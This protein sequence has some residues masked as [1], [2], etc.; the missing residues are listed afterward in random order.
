MKTEVVWEDDGAE[1]AAA[2][3][4][5]SPI[6]DVAFNPDGSRLLVALGRRVVMFAAGTGDV[7]Q[8]ISGHEGAV[9]AVAWS[10]DG[11]RFATGGRDCT[12]V[13][14]T[15]KSEPVLKYKHKASI[16]CLKFNPQNMRLA[17]GST[18]L[19][20]W[21]SEESKVAHLDLES[22]AC[23]VDWSPDG[24]LLA[25]GM[26][27][28]QITLRDRF[29]TKQCYI[30]RPSSVW[31]LTFAPQASR[32]S[33][34]S[35]SPQDVL[36]VGSWDQ[37]LSFYD[38]TGHQI[39]KD[40][41]L[42]FDP[43]TI[44]YF[45]DG[46]YLLI[47]GSNRAVTMWT[48]E[49]IFLKTVTEQQGWIWSIDPR[50]DHRMLALGTQN[51]HYSVQHVVFGTVHGLYADRYAYRDTMTDV[52]IQHLLTEQKV[53]IRTRDYVKKIAIYRDRLAVQLPDRILI[54]ETESD[55]F[56]ETGSSMHYRLRQRILKKLDCNLLVV[57]SI[58]IVLCLESSLQ[59]Y[60]FHGVKVREWFLDAP[61]RYIKV[62]AGPSGREGLLIGLKSGQVYKVFLDNQFPVHLV[63][64][65]KSIRCLDLSRCRTRLAVVDDEAKVY[66]YDLNTKEAIFEEEN[67]NS[68][69][70]NTEVDDMLC[71][72][73]NGELCIRTGDFPVSKHVKQG[74]VV[75]FK[76][77]K[78]FCLNYIHMQTVDIP[79]SASMFR[80]IQAGKFE[81][82]YEIACLGVT[83]SDWRQLALKALEGL[84]LGVA[85]KAFIRIRDVKYTELVN[86][87]EM[88]RKCNNSNDQVFLGDI[89]AYQGKFKEAA[90]VYCAANQRR[91]AIEMFL[92]L[93]NWE[94]AK[95]LVEE[96]HET[97]RDGDDMVNMTDLLQRQAKWLL[98]LK[99][100]KA[101]AEVFWAAGDFMTA[102]SIMGDSMQAMGQ[103]MEKVRG[104]K[105]SDTE[106]LTKAAQYF[107]ENGHHQFAKE[108]YLKMG[109][110]KALMEL[111]IENHKWEE[112][113]ALLKSQ[114]GLSSEI[115]LPY[116]EWLAV[117]DRFDEASEAFRHANKA[118]EAHN[119]LRQL[120]E[121]SIAEHRFNEAAYYT[122]LLASE[123]ARMPE[124]AN[125]AASAVLE[126]MGMHTES[127]SLMPGENPFHLLMRRAELF[128]AYA[129]VH[130]FINAHFS[131]ELHETIFQAAITVL[132]ILKDRPAP[133]GVSR[134]N[135]LFV[136]GQLGMQ[137][138]AY[139]L[140]RTVMEQ[141]LTLRVPQD[142]WDAIDLSNL[143]SRTKPF[144]DKEALQIV[145]YRCGTTNPML[146]DHCKN[147]K[148]PVF[149]CF[150]SFECL[151]LVEFS[152]S[153]E[154]PPEKAES[155]LRTESTRGFGG[156][157]KAGAAAGNDD[158]NVQTMNLDEVSEEEDDGEC[159]EFTN[160]LMAVDAEG[161][162]KPIIADES[163]L[164][165]MD[166]GSVFI[167]NYGK[168][169]P[170][171]YLMNVMPEIPL[172]QCTNCCKVF[173]EDDYDT[174][175]L[176]E[177]TQPGCPFCR[178]KEPTTAKEAGED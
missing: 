133:V 90:K 73:G 105:D 83:D 176:K 4:A 48:R 72:S 122:W 132:A 153:P 82:A 9:N 75:G 151:P 134:V 98:N 174:S 130:Q 135:C 18:D 33:S 114:K 128:S 32:Q 150:C 8:S 64:H 172:A 53:R 36:A 42:N 25:V 143:S 49:G 157:F 44:S 31:C 15:H 94:M 175:V 77:S 60:S 120:T 3:A 159:I 5:G 129:T 131:T 161:S 115:Y 108:T 95:K 144:S 155:L 29:G 164:R 103:L 16:Q 118:E 71:Y 80:Y 66:I 86:R 170:R 37:K 125:S 76:G 17:S 141:L 34:H 169:V 50:P 59:L 148:H 79:Q 101:A 27:S 126:E 78:V 156:T 139:R 166:S 137:L 55:E 142:W 30:R 100:T 35:N 21:S 112:A 93:R 145:C 38:Y 165:Q 56:L 136:V 20:L 147:C 43:C 113:F 40:R 88:T 109:D 168:G 152:V 167:C 62:V 162:F 68:V 57:T 149:R 46:E 140:A 58:D 111:H 171:K 96:M 13:I 178:F 67:A 81:K 138:G 107:R 1:S 11:K 10:R 119:L 28:G 117:N 6:W 163:M 123:C 87:I 45:C 177:G 160:Q 24:L 85:R 99:E 47:A 39:G 7:L 146:E 110:Y 54:Y 124:S 2:S 158:P 74:F 154:I 65:G 89:L 116:A 121:N 127:N 12:V 173:Y 26:F 22:K 104:L 70:W 23:C 106:A 91:K 19:G 63:N 69:A 52:I 51:G 84:S 97:E 92:D 102:I 41:D 61:I 14:W